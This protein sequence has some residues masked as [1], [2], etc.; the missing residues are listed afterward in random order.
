MN[1]SRTRLSLK[2]FTWIDVECWDRMPNNW[3]EPGYWTRLLWGDQETPTWSGFRPMAENRSKSH[4][5]YERATEKK[6]SEFT[7][8]KI[9]R[10]DWKSWNWRRCHTICNFTEKLEMKISFQQTK[11]NKASSKWKS[12]SS[13]K[14]LTGLETHFLWRPDSWVRIADQKLCTCFFYFFRDELTSCQLSFE[15]NVKLSFRD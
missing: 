15:C 10:N 14:L 1:Q 7:A 3:P 13:I 9:T 5:P 4:S 6:L 2:H 11:L 12:S 8:L